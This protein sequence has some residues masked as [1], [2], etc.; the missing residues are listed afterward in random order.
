MA[1]DRLIE[2]HALESRVIDEHLLKLHR[3]TTPTL[4]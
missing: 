4:A 3:H 1:R 2:D